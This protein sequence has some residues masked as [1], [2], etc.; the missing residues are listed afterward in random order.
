MQRNYSIFGS[1]V[2]AVA[3]VCAA[4]PFARADWDPNNPD[5]VA[6]AKWIQL[7]D[8]NTTGMDIL[9]TVQPQ[10][11]TQPSWK[12]LADDFLCIESGPITDVHIWGSW[13]FDQLPVG[14]F[15]PDPNLVRFKLSFHSDVPVS[16]NN[17]FSYPGDELWS[18]VVEPGEFQVSPLVISA[19][20]QFY[21]PNLDQIIGTDTMVYQYNFDRFDDPFVQTEGTIYWLDVQ[22]EVL[23]LP[24]TQPAV[25]GWKTRDPLD[26]HYND[27]ATFADTDGFAGPLLTEW[28]ELRYPEG[29]P[30]EG[31]SIDMA[32]VL[33][34]PEPGSIGLAAIGA[35]GL[36]CC[37]W[38]RRRRK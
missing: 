9:A 36:G 13:L 37:I 34:V 19:N 12:I 38:R 16:E 18:V 8:L 26:G 24:T 7:P 3:V 4:S 5:D 30:F 11:P 29:H 23:G 33:T 1:I 20:E 31:Q 10:S 28:N 6:R 22:A 25:F 17:P 21:D 35:V 15:G 2:I 27:D 32:F 14:E